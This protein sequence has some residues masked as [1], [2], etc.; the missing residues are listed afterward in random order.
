[1]KKLFLIAALMFIS[2][3]FAQAKAVNY[4]GSWR[5]DK[6]KSKNLPTFYENIKSQQLV[7]TQDEKQLKIAVTVDLGQSS[8]DKMNFAYNF[9]GNETK[10][11][12]TIRTPGGPRQV[13]S[14]LKAVV[15]QDGKVQLTIARE[16]QTP[17]GVL[18]GT[19]IEDWELSADGKTLTIHRVDDTPRGKM[20]MDMVFVKN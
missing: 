3:T 13:P 2:F 20:E 8:P 4:A 5:L 9:D 19:T 16:L 12:T 1:M 15:G 11:E 6:T 17:N 10:T 7:V 14:T 18:K